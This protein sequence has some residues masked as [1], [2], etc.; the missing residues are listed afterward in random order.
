MY[1]LFAVIIAGCTLAPEASAGWGGG[2]CVPVGNA[3][4]RIT[5][6]SAHGWYK[7]D[8]ISLALYWNGERIGTLDP[9]SGVWRTEGKSHS[10]DLIATFS[11]NPSV[12]RPRLCL[13]CAC[14]QCP[15]DCGPKAEAKPAKECVCKKD[16]CECAKCPQD[17]V[18][19]AIVPGDDPFP[20]GV[21]VEEIKDAPPYE[22][23]G[24]VCTKEQA[25]AFLTQS[26]LVDD[27]NK[28]FLTIVGDK[29]LRERVLADLATHPALAPYR[30]KLHV[31]AYDTADWHVNQVGLPP[32]VFLQGPPN[33]KGESPVEFR[34]RSYAGPEVLAEAI[35]KA[36]P[37]YKPEADPDPLKKDPPKDGGGGKDAPSSYLLQWLV[38]LVALVGGGLYVWNK[39]SATKG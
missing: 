4:L 12:G 25:Y 36:N 16:A 28:P 14:A 24:R 34:F 29:G 30:S 22:V 33:G 27:R 23:S 9:V 5:Q 13:D 17:C 15:R 20:G 2:S 21:K 8:D 39:K 11:L 1:R 38:T 35:R 6:A 37:N 26:S 3:P 10:V 19:R 18:A 7:N 32:G 31:N